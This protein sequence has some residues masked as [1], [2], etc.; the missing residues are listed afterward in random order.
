MAEILLRWEWRT[1]A[2]AVRSADAVFAA[3]TPASV[4][5][6]DHRHLGG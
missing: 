4:E 1:F 3:M 2:R 5:E 6:S